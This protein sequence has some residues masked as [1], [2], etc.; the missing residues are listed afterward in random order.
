MRAVLARCVEQME[1]VKS[2]A[3]DI[4]D[5]QP[6]HVARARGHFEAFLQQAMVWA[7]SERSNGRGP[8]AVAGVS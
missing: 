3:H 2:T 4:I 5:R 8:G 1:A 6:D 7:E